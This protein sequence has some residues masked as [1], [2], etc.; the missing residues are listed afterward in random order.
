[1]ANFTKPFKRIGAAALLATTRNVN[2]QNC[3]PG[4]AERHLQY[5]DGS[6]GRDYLPSVRCTQ[7]VTTNK[8][9]KHPCGSEW[10]A[11]LAKNERK[12]YDTKGHQGVQ[13]HTGANPHLPGYGFSSQKAASEYAKKCSDTLNSSKK[14]ILLNTEQV[15]ASRRNNTN[16][17]FVREF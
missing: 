11:N 15:L 13:I 3:Y 4:A 17:H 5:A 10:T 6:R 9:G 12:F 8:A 1:M 14:R 7:H 2:A 16:S